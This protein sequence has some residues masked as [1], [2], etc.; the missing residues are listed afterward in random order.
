MGHHRIGLVQR[1]DRI[2]AQLNLGL[3]HLRRDKPHLQE[4]EVQRIRAQYGKLKDVLLG[5]NTRTSYQLIMLLRLLIQVGIRRISHNIYVC[6][7]V[8]MSIAPPLEPSNTTSFHSPETQ[9]QSSL[10]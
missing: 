4:Y 10:P 6:V 2:L 5:V 7:P 8:A 3:E 9:H 1:L